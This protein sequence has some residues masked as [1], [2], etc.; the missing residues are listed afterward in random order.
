MANEVGPA[1]GKAGN[2]AGSLKPLAAIGPRCADSMKARRTK[3]H[4]QAGYTTATDS[5]FV[6]IS[7]SP[8]A[9]LR[10]ESIYASLAASVHVPPVS[11]LDDNYHKL[12]ILD[13]VKDSVDALTD[14]VPF[15][16]RQLLRARRPRIVCQRID[17]RQN[18]LNILFRDAPK[19]LLDRL[20][21]DDLKSCHGL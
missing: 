6:T 16:G 15:F 10:E 11:D 2:K 18:P 5:L 19:V 9:Y 13:F 21:E 3:L 14:A 1:S 4:K 17:P 12:L 20:L 8:S 7:N